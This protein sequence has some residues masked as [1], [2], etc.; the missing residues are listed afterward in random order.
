MGFYV[1]VLLFYAL[2]LQSLIIAATIVSVAAILRFAERYS[3]AKCS[4]SRSPQPRAMCCLS[5]LGAILPPA[6]CGSSGMDLAGDRVGFSTALPGRTCLLL[7]ACL[8]NRGRRAARARSGRHDLAALQIS[9]PW[10][11][12]LPSS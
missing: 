11:S 6:R 1:A 8:W 5:W 9:S 4:P 3:W 12:R 7:S 2:T 10:T